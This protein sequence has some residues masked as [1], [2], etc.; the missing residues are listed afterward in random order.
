M[1]HGFRMALI[2]CLCRVALG[3]K[4]T[5]HNCVS[6]CYYLARFRI[7]TT[8]ELMWFEWPL[9]WHCYQLIQFWLRIFYSLLSPAVHEP[10][11]SDAVG[12]M[13]VL[14]GAPPPPYPPLGLIWTVMLVWRNVNINR[15]VSVL[16]CSISAMHIG[17]VAQW[18]FILPS[19]GLGLVR[20][21]LHLV[22]WPTVIL[23]CLTLLVG[24]S[25]P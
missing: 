25:D 10:L 22:D 23:Q 20:L 24:L 19:R 4:C 12:W 13:D 5:E 3:C 2:H 16:S 18:Y 8:W 14:K 7:C 9:C 11:G 6:L 21:A 1:G 17:W 15:T